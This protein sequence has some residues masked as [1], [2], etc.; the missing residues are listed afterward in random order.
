MHFANEIQKV[1]EMIYNSYLFLLLANSGL[2]FAKHSPNTSVLCISV[3]WLSTVDFRN[4][5]PTNIIFFCL[6][7]E[8]RVDVMLLN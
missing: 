8:A 1:S 7:R 3:Q 5:S 4:M 2:S 6:Q